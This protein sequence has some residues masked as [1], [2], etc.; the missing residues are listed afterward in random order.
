MSGFRRGQ[1]K[2]TDGLRVF[3][4]AFRLI[5][6]N[7]AHNDAFF[8]VNEYHTKIGDVFPDLF[9][10]EQAS[11]MR[12]LMARALTGEIFTVVAEF[13]NPA[14]SN[15]CWE[16]SY[17]PLRDD[18]GKIVGAFHIA[19]D[20]G[21]RLRAEAAIST[22]Q[23]LEQQ[24]EAG[25]KELQDNRAR[26]RSIFETSFSFQALLSKGGVL[27]DANATSR[28]AIGL[29]LTS[30]VGTPFADTPWFSGTPGIEVTVRNAMKD[31]VA[32]AVVRR[33]IQLELPVGV[34]RWFDFAIR[35]IRDDVG[36]ISALWS[37]QSRPQTAVSLKTHFVSRKRWR[38]WGN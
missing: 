33:E 11:V 22:A 37:K 21:P 17:A 13:G 29:P 16:I 25:V 7:Q 28:D 34:R 14:L 19:L 3:D 38:R 4:S 27:L 31:A 10:P 35:P 23:T 12:K 9:V 30:V 8:R 1:S 18:A 26:L 20:V 5:A 15:P 2:R 36:D 6:F 24:L 32:G